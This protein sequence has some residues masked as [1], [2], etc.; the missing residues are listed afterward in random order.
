MERWIRLEESSGLRGAEFMLAFCDMKLVTYGVG[1]AQ[2]ERPAW[3][4]FDD[5]STV[6]FLAQISVFD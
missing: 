1:G 5:V 6:I 4:Y 2:R 3:E